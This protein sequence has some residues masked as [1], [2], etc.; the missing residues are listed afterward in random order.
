MARYIF[1]FFGSCK[2]LLFLTKPFFLQKCLSY[3]YMRILK[4]FVLFLDHIEK[5]SVH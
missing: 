5:N 3:Q 2:G 4:T 1:R